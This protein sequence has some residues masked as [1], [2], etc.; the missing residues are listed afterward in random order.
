MGWI[1][2]HS[3]TANH[4]RVYVM[5]ET[6]QVT[7]T[8]EVVP[9]IKDEWDSL[10]P[11]TRKNLE[12]QRREGGLKVKTIPKFEGIVDATLKPET[13]AIA[14]LESQLAKVEARLNKA[15]SAK[16]LK[17]SRDERLV[18]IAQIADAK[19]AKRTA[20]N[21]DPDYGELTHFRAVNRAS[22]YYRM[23][24][25]RELFGELVEEGREDSDDQEIAQH[26]IAKAVGKRAG[27]IIGTLDL[28]L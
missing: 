27:S 15:T 28:D 14:D 3:G 20:R 23:L 8:P 16:D 1:G 2:S 5:S 21:A 6:T 7:E 25:V 22:E 19:K 4:T 18:L 12:R 17:Q 26:A 11:R 13:D 10:G 24:D 9:S